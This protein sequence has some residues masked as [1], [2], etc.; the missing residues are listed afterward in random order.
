MVEHSTTQIHLRGTFIIECYLFSARR[1]VTFLIACDQTTLYRTISPKL[2]KRN[3]LNHPIIF[4]P[5]IAIVTRGTTSQRLGSISF[6][7][8][9]FLHV[10]ISDSVQCHIWDLSPVP[11]RKSTRLNSS[12]ANISYAVFCLKKKKKNKAKTTQQLQNEIIDSQDRIW[13]L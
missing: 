2:S 1:T 8:F 13:E 6:S 10:A 5:T 11:D 7:F 4:R 9:F 12:H 3:R